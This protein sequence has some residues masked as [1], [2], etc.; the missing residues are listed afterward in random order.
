MKDKGL[1]NS[2]IEILI[3]EDSPTQAKELRYTLERHGFV[4]WVADNGG[5]ALSMIR[6]RKPSMVISDIVMPEMDGYRLCREIKDDGALRDIP[7]ILLTALSDPKDVVKGLEC[8]AD[9]FI[10]KPYDERYILSRLQY[11]L[12]NMHLKDVEKTQLGVE[13]I[14]AGE[15]YFIKSDRI[16]I[17]DLLLSSY[18]AAIMK[19][20]ELAQAR[21]ELRALSDQLEKKVKER[22]AA[23]SDEIMERKRTEAA[24]RESEKR[25]KLLLG[26]VTDYIYS[27]TIRDGCPVATVHG[28]GCSALTGFT[29]EE[30]E[31]DPD[32]WHRMVHEQ[33]R[34]AVMEQAER[35]LA[36]EQVSPLEHRI[37]HRDGSLRWV[38]NTPV[39]RCDREGCLI[40]YD[41]L[42]S[43]ITEKRKL[44]EQL[45][46]AQKM[47]ALGTLVGGVAHD[48][49][50]IITAIIGFGSL[51]QMQMEETD[52]RASHL[53]QILVASDRAATLTRQLLTFCRK[54]EIETR[55]ADLNG[56]VRNVDKMLK[57]L[58]REDI[59]MNI[60]L[61][62]CA[63]NV[64]V[65]EGQI[66]QVLM[67]LATNARDAMPEG[68]R[69]TISTAPFAMDDGFVKIHGYGAPGEYAL[70]IFS[71]SGRGMDEKTRLRMFEPFFT[72]KEE[73]KGTGLGLSVCYGIISQHN[74]YIN[75]Y[76]E[77]GRG[78]TF[79][80]YLPRTDVVEEEAKSV[81]LLPSPRGK[82]TILVVEDD[83]QA[84]EIIRVI[85][86]NSGYRVIEAT[87][88]DEAVAIFA[89]YKDEIRLVIIDMIL[90]KRNG[91]EVHEDI[92]KIRPGVR[93]LFTSG[94]PA[95][96]FHPGEI[97][98]RGLHFIA[99][100]VTPNALLQKLRDIMDKP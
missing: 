17:L 5:K 10:T 20:G 14:L 36:G 13:V 30:Y 37:T 24:L 54:Q 64:M 19:N 12:A 51:A 56:I 94:Y 52:P 44:E 21:D 75:C 62:D 50:N 38:R 31:S 97:V 53:Q 68:G 60:S 28:A 3:V 67:N 100:P 61:N 8:G 25:Y 33:D 46:H 39:P 48:F 86:E 26:S 77:P 40:A 99:K 96:V 63:L 35:I 32:L 23:L 55:P 89:D 79:R 2:D 74:G 15:K 65:D 9:N 16:Q 73:G 45:R 71:D 87:N 66:Q 7:V 81:P 85:L 6:E 90:P 47:E 78:T 93:V 83:A 91:K 42:I 84:R 18:E 82:E 41:G 95:D 76:S 69:L 80:I 34:A 59:E 49:N 70:L 11:I 58:L 43:D 98:E 1:E 92:N 57:R 27:V 72:T 22:T 29:P 4:V 88:G